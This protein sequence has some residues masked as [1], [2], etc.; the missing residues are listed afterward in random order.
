MKRIFKIA[1]M[2]IIAMLVVA[3]VGGS[4]NANREPVWNE[5]ATIYYINLGQLHDKGNIA[6]LNLDK[7]INELKEDGAPAD[8]IKSI[9]NNPSNSGIAADKP[10]YI[11][12]REFDDS[13]NPSDLYFACEISDVD[14]F[15]QTLKELAGDDF[16]NTD[17]SIVGD[18][19]II[20]LE[21]N[22]VIMGYDSERLV[23]LVNTTAQADLNLMLNTQLDYAPADMSRFGN[24]DMASYTDIDKFYNI[25][26]NSDVAKAEFDAEVMEHIKTAY[27]GLFEEQANTIN[28]LTFNDGTIV[29]DTQ[30]EGVSEQVVACYK[31]SNGEL[32]NRL[33]ASPI[34]VLNIGLNGEAIVDGINKIIELVLNANPDITIDNETNIYKNIALGVLGS[35]D[36]DF[37]LALSEANGKLEESDYRGSSP[38]FTTA[39]A[40]FAVDVKDDYIMQNIKTYGGG[41]LTSQG[42]N[43]YSTDVYNNKINIGQHDNVFFVGV[44][45]NGEK[46]SDSAADQKWAAD[47]EDSYAYLM[48][49]FDKFFN[50]SFGNALLSAVYSEMGRSERETTKRI[51][52]AIDELTVISTGEDST[53]S[54]KCTLTLKDSNVNSF[55]QI[56]MLIYNEAL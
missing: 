42:E 21:E 15:D 30:C 49:D 38:V 34:A 1:A 45:N 53:I 36:G 43:S 40:L 5:A 31:K 50:S 6:A 13:F 37:M 46:K 17:F 24:S 44:N 56:V 51:I 25:F 26:V 52:N 39:N 4:R 22:E 48:I 12:I 16:D 20:V 3:C 11:A 32:L 2:S 47:V 18:R 54:S 33:E 19:R 9:L 41:F 7:F 27:N 29:V 8:L 35:F 23:L 14:K 55:E 10:A 28:T